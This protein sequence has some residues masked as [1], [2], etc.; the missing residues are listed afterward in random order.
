MLCVVPHMRRA[1]KTLKTLHSLQPRTDAR[2]HVISAVANIGVFPEFALGK[3][4]CESQRAERTRP[5]QYQKLVLGCSL[6]GYPLISHLG[7]LQDAGI[8]CHV[9][10]EVL[11]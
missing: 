5:K 8:D 9:G 1:K 7:W 3:T 2:M 6:P 11:R 4:A 10:G